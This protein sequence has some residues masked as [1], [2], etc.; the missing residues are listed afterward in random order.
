[1]I[2]G[3]IPFVASETVPPAEQG[4]LT[5]AVGHAN[6]AVVLRAWIPW[7]R[8]TGIRRFGSAVRRDSRAPAAEQALLQLVR[9]L[10]ALRLSHMSGLQRA[11]QQSHATS[12]VQLKVVDVTSLPDAEQDAATDALGAEVGSSLSLS[13]GRLVAA[14]YIRRGPPR[15]D[16]LLLAIHHLA[17]DGSGE[18]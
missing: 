2:A 16:R 17:V 1:M 8:I 18:S 4:M 3:L 15:G 13:D 5:G 10:D 12:S 9:D 6:P 14:A 11:W 7:N